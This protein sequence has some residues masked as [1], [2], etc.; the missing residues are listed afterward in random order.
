MGQLTRPPTQLAEQ[1]PGRPPDLAPAA[2][3]PEEDHSAANKRRA[4]TRASEAGQTRAL[5]EEARFLAGWHADMACRLRSHADA[6][7]GPAARERLGA[8]R[9]RIH[10]RAAARAPP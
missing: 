2:A 5:E 6:A 7:A 1:T 10:A 4:A 9:E 3:Q 8:L